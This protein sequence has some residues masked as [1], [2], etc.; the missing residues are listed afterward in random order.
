MDLTEAKALSH[1]NDIIDIYSNSWGPFDDGIL[2][3]KMGTVLEMAVKQGV[4]QVSLGTSLNQ[5]RDLVELS[6]GGEVIPL[7][8]IN[9][10]WLWYM[11]GHI[12]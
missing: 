2:A 11:Y 7:K 1:N 8:V 9:C 12:N 3:E 5:N 10:Y 6:T 4:E